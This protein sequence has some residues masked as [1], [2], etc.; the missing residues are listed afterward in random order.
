[1]N[2]ILINCLK[3]AIYE[4]FLIKKL[5]KDKYKNGSTMIYMEIYGSYPSKVYGSYTSF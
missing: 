5:V 2:K 1:M 4:D 3:S